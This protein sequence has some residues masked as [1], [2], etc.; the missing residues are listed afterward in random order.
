MVGGY[1]GT[2]YPNVEVVNLDDTDVACAPLIDYPTTI[3]YPTLAMTDGKLRSCG[4][5]SYEAGAMAGCY[6]FDFPTDTWTRTLDLAEPRDS[7]SSSVV[8]KDL[9]FIS[10]TVASTGGVSTEIRSN[11]NSVA[12]PPVPDGVYAP[13]Q[14]TLNDTHVFLADGYNGYTYILNWDEES[15]EI[16]V[17]FNVGLCTLGYATLPIATHFPFKENMLYTGSWPSC[18]LIQN[19]DN[20]AEVVVAGYGQTQIFNLRSLSW[21]DGLVETP[22][23]YA[24][25]EAQLLDTFLVVGGRTSSIYLDTIYE[26]DNLNYRW[27]LRDQ[28]L[29]FPR[30]G[31]G[32]VP[33]PDDVV[34]CI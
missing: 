34:T 11:G 5:R 27:I 15:W 28:R 13:C 33:V 29:S 16:Q 1:D 2:Y 7:P 8:R 17:Y 4:G 6:E 30:E 23:F 9:W 14:V 21:R 24:A 19:P 12:G 26:F 25:R 10:G 32:V 3:W 20:G 22:Y 18:G 31:A